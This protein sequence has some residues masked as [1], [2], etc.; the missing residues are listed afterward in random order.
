MKLRDRGS[1]GSS[2]CVVYDDGKSTCRYKMYI[3]HLNVLQSENPYLMYFR[4]WSNGKHM[5]L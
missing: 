1:M 2:E 4:S 5:K 3:V